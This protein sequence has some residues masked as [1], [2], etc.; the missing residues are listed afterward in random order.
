MPDDHGSD[1]QDEPT[2]TAHAWVVRLASG[3]MSERELA[4]LRAWLD[5]DARHRAAFDEA[6]QIWHAA[7]D[8]PDAF[9]PPAAAAATTTAQ[10]PARMGSRAR[11]PSAAAAAAVIVAVAAAAMFGD[12]WTR[13]RAD[14]VT[15]V[16][17]QAEI[18]LPDGST[19]RLNTNS[20][21]AVSYADGHRRIDLLRGEAY[22]DVR[23]APDRPFRVRFDAGTAT[24]L[25]TAY[26]VRNGD[27]QSAV[28][29]AEGRVAVETDSGQ[30][31]SIMLQAGERFRHVGG[32]TVVEAVDPDRVAAWRRGRIVIAGE[33]LSQAVAELDRYRPGE[34]VVIGDGDTA[35]PVSGVFALDRIDSAVTALAATRG[36][37]VTRIT[38]RLLILH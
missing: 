1:H 32:E 6:R 5:A 23:S 4:E 22:F 17:E 16:G 7:G 30:R 35:E 19:A 34:I 24:A 8:I 31:E 36:M 15:A 21:I 38:D 2:G 10:R 33:S 29:V 13:L 27:R 12:V 28:A 20:A 9:A 25:G 26:A 37:T 18:R 14:H 3:D 11:V